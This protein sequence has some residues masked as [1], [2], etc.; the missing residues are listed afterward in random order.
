LLAFSLLSAFYLIYLGIG[1]RLIGPLLWPA[2]AL[3]A[4]LTIILFRV[5]LNMTQGTE[6]TGPDPLLR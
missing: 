1:S 5:W 2:A 4:V 6:V 3:H